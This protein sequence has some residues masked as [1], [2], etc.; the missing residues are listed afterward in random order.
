MK[1]DFLLLDQEICCAP[2]FNATF[3]G[4][5]TSKEENQETL[6]LVIVASS[7]TSELRPYVESQKGHC[8]EYVN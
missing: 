1:V 5:L 4:S 3:V 8:Q 2:L 7:V 6:P